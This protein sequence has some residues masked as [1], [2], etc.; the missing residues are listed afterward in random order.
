MMNRLVLLYVACLLLGLGNCYSSTSSSSDSEKYDPQYPKSENLGVCQPE[1]FIYKKK[2]GEGGYA[3]VYYAI[4]GLTKTSVALKI[5]KRRKIDLLSVLKEEMIL[6][7]VGNHPGIPQ[8][9]CTM[10][11]PT[12]DEIIFV[13]EYIEGMD[14]QKYLKEKGAFNAGML[15]YIAASVLATLRHVHTHNVVHR[16]I[17]PGNMILSEDGK[18]KLVDF[19]LATSN[20][21]TDCGKFAGTM[22]YAAPETFY[23]SKEKPYGMAVDL[24]SLGLTLY[25]LFT[26]KSPWWPKG[27][28]SVK[29]YIVHREMT[30]W[31]VPETG[32]D[33]VDE[34]IGILTDLNPRNRL[35]ALYDSESFQ[36]LQKLAIFNGVNW[37]ELL[38]SNETDTEE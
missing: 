24:Y 38:S 10:V 21:K 11:D 27:V 15:G 6:R 12:D 17:K 26:N 36:Q 28:S 32:N 16:D 34:L 13:L 22:K 8:H 35:M 25:K 7:H 31:S 1:H 20:C 9:E 3:K 14:L 37:T 4:H 2:L 5:F 19:G 23:C 29:D 18:V 30:N 33:A